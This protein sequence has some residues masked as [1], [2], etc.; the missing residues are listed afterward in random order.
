MTA[1]A[2][3]PNEVAMLRAEVEMLMTERQVLLTT[4]GA[5]SV[6]VANLHAEDLPEDAYAA[7]D[8]LA[9]ALNKLPEETLREALE[10]V[11]PLV[12]KDMEDAAD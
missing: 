8:V 3:N 10:L 2:P 11:R 1:A 6:F 12:L 9:D 4:V 7:G 5:A